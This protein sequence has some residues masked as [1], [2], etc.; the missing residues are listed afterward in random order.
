MRMK[1]IIILFG[2]LSILMLAVSCNSRTRYLYKKEKRNTPDTTYTFH[3]APLEYKIQ[4]YDVLYIF[5]RTDK[6]EINPYFQLDEERAQMGDNRFYLSGYTV[7]DSGYIKVPV[8]GSFHIQGKTIQEARED[9]TI[10][11]REYIEDPI[12]NVKFVDFKITV[13]GAVPKQGVMYIYQE[14]VDI[15]ELISRAGGV[16]SN[17][18]LRNVMILREN[19]K[20]KLMYR[21]N[22]NDRDLLTSEQFY[23]FP[24]DMV[25]VEER[26][27]RKFSDEGLR[28]FI[29]IL[30]VVSSTITTTVLILSLKKK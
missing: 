15:L 25:I 24:N 11:A 23:L 27:F 10:R 2:V 1:R 30:S 12:V 16:N 13:L 7:N 29:S 21:V 8:I 22:L 4:P 28:D 18:N 26:P 14:K 3:T 20:G 6:K 19:E 9:I 5:I 17:G